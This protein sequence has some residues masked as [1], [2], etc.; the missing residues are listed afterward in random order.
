MLT[1]LAI[2][3]RQL[4][5]LLKRIKQYVQ[6]QHEGVDGTWE[7]D[8]HTY[9]RDQVSAIPGSE[10]QPSE[11][12]LIGEALATSESLAKSVAT[13]ARIATIVRCSTTT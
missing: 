7:L 3:I 4:D 10:G 12:F 9:G 5:V 6:E 8:W 2:L 11:V 13:T 1:Q